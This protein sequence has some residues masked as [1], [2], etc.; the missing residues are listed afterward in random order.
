MKLTDC[1]IPPNKALFRTDYSSTYVGSKVTYYCKNDNKRN[2][3]AT[4]QNNGKWSAVPVSCQQKS[5]SYYSK[6]VVKITS[7]SLFRFIS[8]FNLTQNRK[9]LALLNPYYNI[10]AEKNQNHCLFKNQT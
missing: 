9:K 8:I 4:C 3:S 2:G 7:K 6:S 5:M 10:R 1:G